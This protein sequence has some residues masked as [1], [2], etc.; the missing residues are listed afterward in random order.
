MAQT[1][2]LPTTQDLAG[3]WAIDGAHSS[4]E[5]SAKHMMISTVRGRFDDFSG[6]VTLDQDPSKSSVEVTFKT[7][8]ISSGN[9]DRDGHLRSPD[10]LDVE[11]HPDMAFVSTTVELTSATTAKVTGDLTIR[12]VTRPAT[13]DVTFSN[14]LERDLWG[15]TRVAFAA[16]TSI[17]RKDWDLTWNKAMESGGVLVGDKVDITLDIAAVKQ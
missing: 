11:N 5:F 12:S 3:T 13:L 16:T 15:K 1:A 17:S 9:P 14:Y 7:A 10:F 2:T 6:T 4:A 8:S